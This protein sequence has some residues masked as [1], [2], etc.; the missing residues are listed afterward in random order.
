MF[1]IS[2]IKNIKT[3]L[4]NSPLITPKIYELSKP[5]RQG[6]KHAN[7]LDRCAIMWRH[8]H[9]TYKKNPSLLFR[10]CAQQPC[11]ICWFE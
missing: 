8:K 3:V 5:R 9:E 10:P 2:V 6:L 1:T 7:C 4:F 11:S